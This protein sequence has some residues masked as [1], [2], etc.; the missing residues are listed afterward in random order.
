MQG[1]GGQSGYGCEPDY[2]D[3]PGTEALGGAEPSSS[4]LLCSNK[5]QEG[6]PHRELKLR[7]IQPLVVDH[8]ER[9]KQIR[10]V[11]LDIDLPLSDNYCIV[12]L[13]KQVLSD[14]DE[15][16]LG[17]SLGEKRVP[18]SLQ[19]FISDLVFEFMY[20]SNLPL[21]QKLA[22]L[23]LGLNKSQELYYIPAI[24]FG[25]LFQFLENSGSEIT[26]KILLNNIECLILK[27]DPAYLALLE[28]HFTKEE[29]QKAA[30]E[31]MK[32]EGMYLMHMVKHN[33][34]Y[35]LP[36]SLGLCLLP[37][38]FVSLKERLS[39]S[40]ASDDHFLPVRQL[41][42]SKPL[43]D[44]LAV[45]EVNIANHPDLI[46]AELDKLPEAD[47]EKLL[48][49]A[50]ILGQ[51]K[52]FDKLASTLTGPIND[53]LCQQSRNGTNILHL[54]ASALSE[55][56]NRSILY[57]HALTVY[58]PDYDRL[59][60]LVPAERLANQQN[61][62]G[63]TPL[64]LLYRHNSWS[65]AA[66]PMEV[67]L[68]RAR[69]RR[70]QLLRFSGH[71]PVFR[72][73]QALLEGGMPR[74]C[75]WFREFLALYNHP[76][77]GVAIPPHTL[78]PMDCT[79]SLCGQLRYKPAEWEERSLGKVVEFL[80]LHP[81]ALQDEQ[82][83]LQLMLE[84]QSEGL[85]LEYQALVLK[86]LTP[87]VQKY[88]LDDS[89]LTTADSDSLFVEPDF[90]MFYN[91]VH[92]YPWHLIGLSLDCGSALK[93]EETFTVPLMQAVKC[94]QGLCQQDGLPELP[95][96]WEQEFLTSQNIEPYGRSL[97]FPS[98][99]VSCGYR[100]F[101]FLKQQP[102]VTEK[103][104]DF[105]REQPHLAFFR[106]H[107]STLGLESALIKPRGVFRL[108]NAQ[109]K[110][111]QCG[112]PEEMLSGIAFAGD[113]S[114]CLQV[115]DDDDNTRLYHHYSYQ[116]SG[117]EGLSVE[118]SLAGIRLFARDGGRLLR[119][120]FQPPDALS[121]FHNSADGRGWSPTPFYGGQDVPGTLGE[122]NALDYPNI[123][124]TPVGMRDLADVR[125]FQE[126]TS[127]CFGMGK[128]FDASRPEIQ[129]QVR[130]TELGKVFYGLV[131]NW[132][133]V[134]HDTH[135]LDY[136]NADHMRQL[137][138]ELVAIAAD[139]F[140]TAFGMEPEAMKQHI[141]Q[142]FPEEALR[143]AVSECGY[144]CDPTYRYVHDIRSYRF[145]DEIYPGQLDHGFN[146]YLGSNTK[147]LTD[148]GLRRSTKAR[149][150][151]LGVDNGTM[152]LCHLDSLLWFCVLAGWKADIKA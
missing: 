146:I 113:G 52:L 110:L 92:L 49:C 26:R 32:C 46:Q 65:L 19:R 4:H 48:T 143:R 127:T 44:Q 107:R 95:R 135:T 36:E 56:E 27:A 138:S 79:D 147:K 40:P 38:L 151:N 97:A 13:H 98:G 72:T 43:L 111:R 3:H 47:R 128:N 142:A 71:P 120:G 17:S 15:S 136:Q 28:Q 62:F 116:T 112:L 81:R 2:L 23:G 84:I 85:P 74:N 69:E 31:V 90:K 37:A 94:H 82:Q 30:V 67:D 88:I 29:I 148:E 12:Q 42:S 41:L 77:L 99:E 8:L 139:L 86:K 100:R 70:R 130:V 14:L 68:N 51:G 91:K 131:I 16:L 33:P 22:N 125:S 66:S 115:F 150:A 103:W 78:K 104:E 133:R 119:Q 93:T 35:R 76:A 80:R 149:G 58:S 101:K 145:P 20:P 54:M 114:A 63:Y 7:H 132:L 10:Q 60:A 126:V 25:L 11:I 1:L 6:I 141:E 106:E 129:G 121:C 75:N 34:E 59:F 105:I 102:G 108:P 123:A 24:P 118:A 39:A 96:Q 73:M 64:E 144:W 134:R 122:W 152:P 89:R 140:G 45:L 21:L 137:A 83:A 61:R 87:A 117:E 9:L 124:P 50:F 109:E 55:V 53:I 5:G 57:V 18:D